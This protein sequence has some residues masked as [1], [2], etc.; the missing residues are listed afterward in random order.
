M[1]SRSKVLGLEGKCPPAIGSSQVCWK[2]S[3]IAG[4]DAGTATN[5][6]WGYKVWAV[7]SVDARF[8]SQRRQRLAV[9]ICYVGSCVV[10][11]KSDRA[12]VLMLALHLGGPMI[13]FLA[14]QLCSKA[15]G[16]RQ[17]FKQAHTPDVRSH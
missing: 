5:D 15:V 16:G 14:L 12:V 13:Q 11:E 8:P 10:A 3:C 17:Q 1:S 2:R 6:V 9:G 7:L 4:P